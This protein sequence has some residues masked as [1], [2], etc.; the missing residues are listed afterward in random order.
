MV[1]SD[2]NG[3]LTE[4]V[5]WALRVLPSICDVNKDGATNVVDVQLIVNQV[6]GVVPPTSD[7]NGDGSVNIVDVQAVVNAALGLGCPG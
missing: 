4:S 5:T 1:R 3:I 2:P 7:V 6:L